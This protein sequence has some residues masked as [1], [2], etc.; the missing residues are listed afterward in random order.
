[1]KPKEMTWYF[2]LSVIATPGRIL[3][4]SSAVDSMLTKTGWTLAGHFG[5][6]LIGTISIEKP[7]VT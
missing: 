6:W 3:L 5:T 7:V 1:M 2:E 4:Y